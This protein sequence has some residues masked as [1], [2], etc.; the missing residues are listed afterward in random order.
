MNRESNSSSN[1]WVASSD[2]KLDLVKKYVE[3]SG[4]DINIADEFGYTP[5]YVS[6]G[7]Q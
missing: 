6:I 2:G 5:L 1:I 4:M 7:S 3:E